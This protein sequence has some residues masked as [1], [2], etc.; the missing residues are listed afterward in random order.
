MAP[1]FQFLQGTVQTFVMLNFFFVRQIIS[2]PPRYGTNKEV[3]GSAQTTSIFQFLQG[4][5]QTWESETSLSQD[6]CNFNSSKV[7]YKR[8]LMFGLMVQ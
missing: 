4:T 5:V 3:G 8:N 2:I 6:M 7:R 1:E